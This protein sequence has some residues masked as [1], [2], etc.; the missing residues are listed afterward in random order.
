MNDLTDPIHELDAAWKVLLQRWGATKETWKDAVQQ[1]FEQQH[2]M[3]LEEQT[4]AVQREL[5]ALAQVIHK[6]RRVVK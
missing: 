3:P 1:E 2:W 6:A 4:R 5:E